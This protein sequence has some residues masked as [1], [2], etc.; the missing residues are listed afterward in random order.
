MLVTAGCGVV[1][2]CVWAWFAVFGWCG[3]IWFSLA[4]G[5]F[6]CLI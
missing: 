4:T 2:Y 3:F 5:C 6:A 1:R